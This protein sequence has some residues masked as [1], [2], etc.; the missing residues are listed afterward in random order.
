MTATAAPFKTLKSEETRQRIFLAARTLFQDR[1]YTAT[2]MRAIAE[3]ADVSVGS[4]YYYFESKESLVLAFYDEVQ[5]ELHRRT[6]GI[7]TPGA[8]LRETLSFILLTNIKLLEPNREFLDAVLRA[9]LS[10]K[11]PLSPF[12]REAAATRVRGISLFREA[13]R[14][15]GDEVHP[16]LVAALPR[17]LWLYQMWLILFWLGDRSL[18]ARKTRRLVAASTGAVD[19]AV[20]GLGWP[21]MGKLRKAVLSMV[22]AC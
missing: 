13:V 21:G 12:S 20:R 16:Q 15:A 19:L 6:R 2:T 7:F 14:A 11:H 4:A 10:P 1:G 3:E 17:G 22:D 18:S 9:A 8:P 5:D